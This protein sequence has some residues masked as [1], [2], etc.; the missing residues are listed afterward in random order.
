MQRHLDGAAPRYAAELRLRRADGRWDWVMACDAVVERDAEGRAPGLVGVRI[1][2]TRRKALERRLADTARR[3]ELTGLPNRT[4]LLERLARCTVRARADAGCRYAVRFVDL[5]HFKPVNDTLG[6]A[7]G[8]A[9]LRQVAERL[10]A[11][12]RATDA[13]ARIAARAG[14]ATRLG[15]DEFVVLLDSIRSAEDAQAVAQRL[16]DALAAPFTVAGRTLWIGASVGIVVGD[17]ARSI[18]KRIRGGR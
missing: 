17:A 6:H 5:D 12:L 2:I 16:I 3:D 1:D 10:R 11:A 9:L 14:I 15:G 4:A 8:D 7:A 13:L 18:W